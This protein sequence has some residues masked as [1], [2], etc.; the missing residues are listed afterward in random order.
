MVCEM[1][2]KRLIFEEYQR[3]RLIPFAW[4]L[5]DCGLFVADVA[6]RL[7]GKDPAEKLRGTYDSKVGIKRIM[8]ERG[9]KNLGDGAASIYP[10]IPVSMARSGDWAFLVN[11]DGT[12]TLGV[13]N[14][15]QILA[16]AE[17]GLAILELTK[18]TRAFRVLE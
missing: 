2:V 1:N 10:E 9:W 16:R 17:G 3:Q 11:E 7:T 6:L 12:E 15:S 14:G 8:V 4:G 5:A 18:A 13:V